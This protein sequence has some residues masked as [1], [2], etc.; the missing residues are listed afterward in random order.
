MLD[1]EDPSVV[2]KFSVSRLR[3][4]MRGSNRAVPSAVHGAPLDAEE[5]RET[6]GRLKRM[7]GFEAQ[8]FDPAENDLQ[9]EF[10]IHRS[11]HDYAIAGGWVNGWVGDEVSGLVRRGP[12]HVD[13]WGACGHMYFV[14]ESSTPSS[15]PLD[16]CAQG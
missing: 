12:T 14:L 9:R 16:L 6:L 11:E 8:D 1:H 3:R 15:T 5:S 13:A 7:A 2:D 10:A 4:S